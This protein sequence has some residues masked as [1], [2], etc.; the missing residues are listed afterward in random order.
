MS[1]S[2]F[3]QLLKNLKILNLS[4]SQFLTKTPNFLNLPN[5]E[6]L[7][8][9]GCIKLAEVHFSIGNLRRLVSLNLR[10]CK[11]L[12]KLPNSI[13]R[14]KSLKTLDISGCPKI[15]NLPENFG[16]MESLTEFVAEGTGITEVP[17]SITRMKNL[18]K[19]SLN[20]REEPESN[21]SLMWSPRG[22]YRTKNVR[23]DSLF[24]VRSL[25]TLRLV[26][27]GL[28]NEANLLDGIGNLKFLE[29]LDLHRNQFSSLPDTIRHL[30]K[31]ERIILDDCT[32]LEKLPILPPNLF[33]LS[34]VNCTLLNKFRSK[35]EFMIHSEVHGPNELG[36][37]RSP[38]GLGL[39][40][41]TE[42]MV[43]MEWCKNRKVCKF[44]LRD[45][46]ER[47]ILRVLAFVLSYFVH[48]ILSV[49]MDT[50]IELQMSIL[51]ESYGIDVHE[52]TY[53]AFEVL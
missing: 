1:L 46:L 34:A 17:F 30:T 3:L 15:H 35:N 33:V 20:V 25:R 39:A 22:F 18:S 44:L 31:L 41:A 38:R 9:R 50:T 12:N 27:C 29:N 11:K 23:V 19:V 7:I 37:E 43:H 24:M 52:C 28:S 32:K 51:C 16:D 14:V 53:Q 13:C 5:V 2:L 8:L 48:Q 10:N 45:G 6:D 40:L 36:L 26:N 47:F 4:Y 49:L 42:A 21:S